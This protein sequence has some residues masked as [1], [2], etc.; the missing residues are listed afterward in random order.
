MTGREFI[1]DD[2]IVKVASPDPS[3]EYNKSRGILMYLPG[4][5]PKRSFDLFVKL[6]AVAL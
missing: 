1:P 6:L 2:F 3:A 4:F 5:D